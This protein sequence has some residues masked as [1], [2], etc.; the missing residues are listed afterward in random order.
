MC[1]CC[2]SISE[3]LV[4]WA[5]I[6]PFFGLLFWFRRP[7]ITSFN[8]IGHNTCREYIYLRNGLNISIFNF[9][10][11]NTPTIRPQ[12]PNVIFSNIRQASRLV[13]GNCASICSELKEFILQQELAGFCFCCRLY[14]FFQRWGKWSPSKFSL[15]LFRLKLRKSVFDYCRVSL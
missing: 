10:W 13:V 14:N 9:L 7:Y 15:Q 11:S 8:R 4:N 2:S 6:F 5:G 1:C 3:V 12:A